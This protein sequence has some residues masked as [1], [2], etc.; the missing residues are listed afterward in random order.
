VLPAPGKEEESGME[1][2]MQRSVRTTEEGIIART[3]AIENS[4]PVQSMV[5]L[6]RKEAGSIY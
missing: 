4:E 2:R 5:F 3:E 6:F 1:R